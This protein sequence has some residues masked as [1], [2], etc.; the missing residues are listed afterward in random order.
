MIASFSSSSLP[1]PHPT[2]LIYLPTTICAAIESLPAADVA[3][4][5]HAL[6]TAT[7]TPGATPAEGPVHAALT[8]WTQDPFARGAT[9]TPVTVGDDRSPLDFIELGKP[10][11]AWGGGRL[12]FAG[13]HTDVDL[14]GSVTG[15][16]ESGKKEAE[17]IAGLLRRLDAAAK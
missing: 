14:R 10:E 8:S 5:A 15:A 6:L 1:S 3:A 17:R 4:A 11:R 2:L 16:T 7:I 13:E 9:T 12:G